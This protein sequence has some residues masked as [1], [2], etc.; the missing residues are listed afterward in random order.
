M[1]WLI[2]GLVLFLGIHS[3][4]IA[5]PALRQAQIDK[6]GLNTWKGIYAL[7]AIVGFVILVWGYGM[8]RLDPVVF[9]V[10]PTWMSHVVAL[11]MLPAMIFLVA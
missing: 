11:L 8:A 4:R 6:R 2:V 5:A 10:A 7:I 9:W 1:I 3:V